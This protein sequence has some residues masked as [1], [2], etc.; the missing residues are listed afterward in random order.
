MALRVG[1][2]SRFQIMRGLAQQPNVPSLARG[3]FIGM[4]RVCASYK[5]MAIAVGLRVAHVPVFKSY[6]GS[7]NNPTSP[8]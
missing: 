3:A 6:A 8:R 7:P 2:R 5:P 1:T 4:R